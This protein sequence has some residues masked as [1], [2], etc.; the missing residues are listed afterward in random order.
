MLML[1]LTLIA[2][3]QELADMLKKGQALEMTQ[4]KRG[5][6]AKTK[7]AFDVEQEEFVIPEEVPK[8]KKKLDA[9]KYQE[10]VQKQ[11]LLQSSQQGKMLDPAQVNLLI[12][13]YQFNNAQQTSQHLAK[14]AALQFRQDKDPFQQG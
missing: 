1:T 3:L 12:P 11:S 5:D 2:L 13:N 10:M 9:Q 4:S 6:L 14:D 7:P 8:I